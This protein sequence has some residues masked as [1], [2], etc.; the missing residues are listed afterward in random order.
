MKK[1]ILLS[2]IIAIFSFSVFAQQ[3]PPLYRRPP[4]VFMVPRGSFEF[5]EETI[6]LYGYDSPRVYPRLDNSF[7]LVLEI[8]GENFTEYSNLEF[9][10]AAAGALK[11]AVEDN[12]FPLDNFLW[13]TFKTG[14]IELQ[15]PVSEFI[16]EVIKEDSRQEIQNSFIGQTK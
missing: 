1:I 4:S 9:A 14:I 15:F 13:I 12:E 16:T 5:I 7:D 10:V 2:I 8:S 6:S 11:R 3:L